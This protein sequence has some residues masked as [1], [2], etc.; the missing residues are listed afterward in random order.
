MGVSSSQPRIRLGTRS[1][2]LARWQA[3]WVSAR[4]AALGIAVEM[5]H[6]TTQGDVKT[7]PL[8]QIGGQGLFTKEIQRALLDNEIDLAVHSLKDLPTAEVPGLAIA[9]VPARESV[10]DVLVG[11]FRLL[12]ELP[13]GARIGTGSLRR[14]A[15]LL[16]QRP[17]LKLL[18]I[19]GNVDTRLKKL[20]AGDYDAIVLAQAGL[21]RLGLADRITYIIPPQVMLPAVGQ[22]ALGLETRA[23]DTTT[24]QLLQPLNHPTTFAAITAERTLLNSLRAGCLAPVG[25]W[26]RLEKNLLQMDAVVLHPDGTAKL[27]AT[28]TAPASDAALLGQRV[29]DDLLS[30]GATELITAARGNA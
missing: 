7:G 29:A 18:E 25:A 27:T 3:E 21:S 11:P 1:S 14:R 10:N 20:D 17:D 19:R 24:R 4:L 2:P 12:D 8:G 9:A 6:I 28:G 26:A 15:Q 13:E 5:I 22:G 16:N 23:D 30:R